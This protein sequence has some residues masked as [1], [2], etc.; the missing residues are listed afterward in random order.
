MTYFSPSMPMYPKGHSTN[1]PYNTW[2]PG[3]NYHHP[4]GNG[5]FIDATDISQ[6]QAAMYY[7]N[8]HLFQNSP[9]WSHEFGGGSGVAAPGGVLQPS[10]GAVTVGLGS[11]SIGAGGV[12][13]NNLATG[14]GGSSVA[15]L[16]G[17]SNG[18]QPGQQNP[19]GGLSSMPSP[20]PT[21]SG[22]SEMS[23]PSGGQEEGSPQTVP[24]PNTSNKSPF[25][26][27]TKNPQPATGKF[28]IY[29]LRFMCV[30][31]CFYYIH[32]E[33]LHDANVG[34]FILS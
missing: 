28:Y 4:P 30:S 8:P 33:Q 18:N 5:Q 20:P 19:N 32:L 3:M 17:G 23:S 24:R 22:G 1:L 2:Y 12:G 25:Q 10:I 21:L 15:P 11:G 31:L 29:D 13:G 14:S 26:W 34:T 16:S 6:H 27:M 9:E 7:S